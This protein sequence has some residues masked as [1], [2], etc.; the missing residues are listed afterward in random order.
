MKDFNKWN[1][2]KKRVD[3]KTKISIP[4]NRQVYWT[5][6]EENIPIKNQTQ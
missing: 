5:C 3:I 6:I 4:K 2:V 1:E